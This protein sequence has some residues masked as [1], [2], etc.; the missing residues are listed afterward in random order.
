MTR[1]SSAKLPMSDTGIVTIGMIDALNDLRKK[2]I[3]STGSSTAMDAAR[4]ALRMGS[5]VTVL[6]RR[7]KEEMPAI[8]S[9]VEGAEEEE[10]VRQLLQLRDAVAGR[11]ASGL[12]SAPVE[13][14]RER[15]INL[16]NN[17]FHD[18]LTGLPSIAAYLE[19]VAQEE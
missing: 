5:E 10:I 1:R 12:R 13:A 6:Y 16:V 17:F 19:E 4:T 11:A 14:A 2:K 15:V 9:E 7:T 8:E 3:T 18:K